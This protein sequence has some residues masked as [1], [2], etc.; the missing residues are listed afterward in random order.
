M[1]PTDSF[2]EWI[3][4]FIAIRLLIAEPISIPESKCGLQ[5]CEWTASPCDHLASIVGQRPSH[6]QLSKRKLNSGLKVVNYMTARAVTGA[7]IET[8]VC[9]GGILMSS[10]LC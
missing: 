10:A 4:S 9:R 3:A 6:I 8:A 1:L 2:T 7:N 5:S